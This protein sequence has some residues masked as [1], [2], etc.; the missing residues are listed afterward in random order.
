MAENVP[1][2]TRQKIRLAL[3]IWQNATCLRFTEG[4]P[5]SDRIEFFDGG[6]C[7]SF[8]GRAGGT[9]G[10]SIAT[11]G[12]DLVGIIA[13]EIGHALGTFHEQARPDQSQHIAVHYSNIPAIRWN[14]FQPIGD[15]QAQTL[16]LPYDAGSV[17]HYGPFGFAADQFRPTISTLDKHW[18][19]TIGQREAPSFLDIEA[20]NRAYGCTDQCPTE[21]WC[22]HGGYTD[23]NDCSRCVCPIGFGGTFCAEVQPSPCGGVIK[24]SPM[25]QTVASPDFPGNFPSD[26]FC[27]WLF[28]SPPQGHL[29]IEFVEES[30]GY[31]C[32]DTCDKAFVE[33]KMGPDFR[34][35]GYRFC[36]SLPPLMTFQSIGEE[37]VIIHYGGTQTEKRAG[38]R[39]RVWSEKQWTVTTE[40][41]EQISTETTWGNA[42]N[43]AEVSG[44]ERASTTEATMAQ[45]NGDGQNTTTRAKPM[46]TSQP[47]PEVPM[48]FS[49]SSP[50]VMPM[51]FSSSSPSVMPVPSSSSS[52][53]PPPPSSNECSLCLQWSEWSDCSQMCGGCGRKTRRR[54]CPSAVSCQREEKRICNRMACP[55]GTNF[56]FNNGE[57]HLL[58]KG[59][60]VGLFLNNSK[61]A[62]DD[63]SSVRGECGPL[64]NNENPFLRIISSL[65]SSHDG[66][67]EQ[68]K[69]NGGKSKS[70]ED[71]NGQ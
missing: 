50:S 43:E 7:S 29:F 65:L 28:R 62:K 26:L 13:H 56:L 68:T 39:A 10:I 30:F 70:G 71:K 22:L 6:G 57:F 23:P 49:S 38:F 5:D 19:F 63:G 58:W 35:T 55:E 27:V 18:L 12:C 31:P 69:R 60:C 59:C 37:A 36:C 64:E 16:G 51:P 21:L 2:K 20:I 32:E 4:G 11:P 42:V 3:A 48:P 33:L 47:P 46:P 15:D 40:E 41:E 45:T 52:S 44:T 9:Q 53:P 1:E 14:N 8:V 54:H 67:K 25:V 34:V 66:Q 61:T 17:M 24:A